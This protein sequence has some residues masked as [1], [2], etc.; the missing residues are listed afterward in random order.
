MQLVLLSLHLHLNQLNSSVDD[1][2][3][4]AAIWIYR[5]NNLR[6]VVGGTRKI[7]RLGAGEIFCIGI[8]TTD[9]HDR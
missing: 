3:V 8:D 2:D 1:D 4:M 5:T 9:R 7:P 6:F